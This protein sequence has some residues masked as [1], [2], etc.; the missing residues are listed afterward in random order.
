[1][2]IT[3][4]DRSRLKMSRC[5]LCQKYLSDAEAEVDGSDKTLKVTGNCKTH[6]LIEASTWE[7]K[8]FYLAIL[9]GNDAQVRT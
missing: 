6:G 2:E 3:F 5:S 7:Y 8:D 4:K 1:M 9:G